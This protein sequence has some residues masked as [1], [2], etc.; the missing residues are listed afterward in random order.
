M[1]IEIAN[2]RKK[3]IKNGWNKKTDGK[4]EV[5]YDDENWANAKK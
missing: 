4:T 2:E 5:H 1:R 3:T